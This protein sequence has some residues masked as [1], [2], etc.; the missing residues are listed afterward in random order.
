MKKTD[1]LFEKVDSTRP[2]TR[3]SPFFR[4]TL[5]MN[6]LSRVTDLDFHSLVDSSDFFPLTE[7]ERAVW[8]LTLFLFGLAIAFLVRAWIKFFVTPTRG[9]RLL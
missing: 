6:F 9:V 1:T 5:S 4:A 3:K 7:E 8:C 2:T